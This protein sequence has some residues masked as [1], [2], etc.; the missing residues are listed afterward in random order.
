MVLFSRKT[1]TPLAALTFKAVNDSNCLSML[2]GR[3]SPANASEPYFQGMMNK[4]DQ[5]FSLTISN[6]SP[7]GMINFNILHTPH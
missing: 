5:A 7:V 2:T 1:R 4:P 3:P 6:L